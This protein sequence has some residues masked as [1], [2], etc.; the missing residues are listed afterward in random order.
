MC[1]EVKKGL[2]EAYDKIF[3]CIRKNVRNKGITKGVSAQDSLA[4]FL[5]TG[6][7]FFVL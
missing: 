4:I 3:M 6:E 2:P 1:V 7:I 5:Y